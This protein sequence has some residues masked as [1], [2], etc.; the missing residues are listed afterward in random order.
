MMVDRIARDKF[1]ELLRHFAAGRLTNDEYEDA[2]FQILEAA[3][4]K[5]RLPGVMFSRVW[6]L[7]DDLRVHRLRDEHALADEG[8]RAVARWV[9]FLHS[10]LEYEWPVR[11][12][13]SLSSCLLRLCTLGLA[14]VIL[15]PI[16]ERR[17][18]RTGSWDLWPFFRE[19]D[20]E[21]ARARPRLL[22]GAS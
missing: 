4:A 1:A 20:Y 11:S 18:R 15:T 14:G 13:I 8:R 22:N 21:S 5:D 3:D 16:N 6:H 7:Y 2:A 9:V 17:L 10:D 12:F 19:A